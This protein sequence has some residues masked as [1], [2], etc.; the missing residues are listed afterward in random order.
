MPC[1]QLLKKPDCTAVCSPGHQST[2]Q[3]V[4]RHIK[5]HFISVP[6]APNYI[7]V[8]SSKV[9][10]NRNTTTTPQSICA[11]RAGT[12]LKGRPILP[13]LQGQEGC[14]AVQ[15]GAVQCGAVRCGAV[16]CGAVRCGA[17]RCSAVRCGAVRCGAQMHGARTLVGGFAA[18][19]QY[20]D[21]AGT[22][23]R[24]RA[25]ELSFC[26]CE[27]G[28]SRPSSDYGQG[29]GHGLRGF[30]PPAR[31]PGLMV[32]AA[33]TVWPPSGSVRA[34]RRRCSPVHV[35]VQSLVRLPFPQNS[36]PRHPHRP[37]RLHPHHP[38]PLPPRHRPHHR[39]PRPQMQS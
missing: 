17:V 39:H 14:S 33:A 28:G 23:L 34:V 2:F 27:A 11:C 6:K 12:P 37:L 4:P 18:C 8:P 16:R 22:T 7:S 38:R 10:S 3:S 21:M 31:G 5:P 36:K 35:F 9:R 30:G 13:N 19:T 20:V 1:I 24:C 32:G 25:C 15:C 29:E 26:R